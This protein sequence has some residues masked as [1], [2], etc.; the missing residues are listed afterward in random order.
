MSKM[1]SLY[2]GDVRLEFDPARH[3]YTW[4]GKFIPGVTSILRILDK[5]ALIQWAANMAAEYV[6]DALPLD[7]STPIHLDV[8]K[9]VCKEAKSAHRRISKDAA[10]VGTV[11]H[12]FAERALVEQ[13]VKLPQDPLA[14]KGAE[15][16][17][18]WLHATEH[19]AINVE[20]MVFSKTHYYAG[21]CDFYGHIA[22]KVCV[23]DLKTSSGLYP[24]MLLQIAAY[25]IAISEET[26]EQINDGWI[27][28]L[29]K[30]TGKCEPYHIA[31]TQTLRDAFLRVLDTHRAMENV[32]GILKEVK[33]NY[34]DLKRNLKWQTS[35]KSSEAA[36]L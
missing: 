29:C 16:F 17:L 8:L 3:A 30:K 32:D 33:T 27:V 18:G 2:G 12:A 10:D 36:Q 14:R 19:H 1:I 35:M 26:G 23:M 22:G 21:T 9:D 7:D 28:R 6:L 25:A 13:R 20:R 11:V 24:E 4:N 31:I 5:P 34:S 15:A